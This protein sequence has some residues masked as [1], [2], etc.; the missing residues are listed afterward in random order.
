VPDVELQ[1]VLND[2]KSDG[3]LDGPYTQE[4]EGRMRYANQINGGN[5]LGTARAWLRRF[6]QAPMRWRDH[7]LRAVDEC[8][9]AAEFIDLLSRVSNLAKQAGPYLSPDWMELVNV[10]LCIG[11]L[12]PQSDA[13]TVAAVTAW[14]R[15]D[16]WRPGPDIDVFMGRFRDGVRAFLSPIA[17][18]SADS[19]SLKRFAYDPGLWATSG[20][21][22]LHTTLSVSTGDGA[23]GV[24]NSKWA[25]ATQL[26]PAM[27]EA[28]MRSAVVRQELSCVMKRE[29]G[30][31]RYV[32]A[33]DDTMYWRMAYVAHA[34]ERQ[35]ADS[36]HTPLFWTPE[37]RATWDLARC[38]AIRDGGRWYTP[39]DQSKFDHH[40]T[41]DMVLV[42]TE[43]ICAAARRADPDNA[44]LDAMCTLI[45]AGMREPCS[46]TIS[47]RT[48]VEVP[49]ER[50]LLSGWRWTSLMNTAANYAI[51]HCARSYARVPEPVDLL[52]MGDD[53]TVSWKRLDHG[54][55]FT[56]A[57]R[58]MGFDVNPAKTFISKTRDE[59]LRCVYTAS[60][61][62]G[63]AT[64]MAPAILYRKPWVSVP[65]TREAAFRDTVANWA[66]YISRLDTQGLLIPVGVAAYSERP[67]SVQLR[68][69]VDACVADAAA[70]VGAGADH[71][72]RFLRTPR[73][74]GGAGWGRPPLRGVALRERLVGDAG[75]V[76]SGDARVRC[77]IPGVPR[78]V[79]A[80]QAPE[81]FAA[82]RHAW[83]G[84]VDTPL[85]GEELAASVLPK[86]R[87]ALTLVEGEANSA[88]Y[89]DIRVARRRPRIRWHADVPVMGRMVVVGKLT[90]TEALAGLRDLFENHQ[91]ARTALDELGL[92]GFKRWVLGDT[93]IPWDIPTFN[94]VGL[95]HAT[96]YLRDNVWGG[97]GGLKR[98]LSAPTVGHVEA[99]TAVLALGIVWTL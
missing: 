30:K 79:D 87:G 9:N 92:R 82:V 57:F 4:E 74:F 1:R 35:L 61:I 7:V 75:V 71:V 96:S 43:E 11:F 59:F 76:R 16:G 17:S 89:F 55:R 83:R 14:V 88:E 34:I 28:A 46:V 23:F 22:R 31:V 77:S 66:G 32:I 45:E 13:E 98:V 12:P 78:E 64:R 39:V 6:W 42:L 85:S 38:R 86:V 24:Q 33:G 10:G 63:Y 52:A 37:K 80:V 29:A 36:P 93:A 91:A 19:L 15:D 90:T 51:C 40:F 73:G 62:R 84:L 41:K 99:M 20:A 8:N 56:E 81:W 21:S 2:F 26:D 27:V 48:R 53:V 44:D 97:R 58:H 60:G 50:G 69:A 65:P 5:A 67:V 72:W 49:Y 68:A 3:V 70:L 25:T 54:V 47:G 94:P 95:A 18:R